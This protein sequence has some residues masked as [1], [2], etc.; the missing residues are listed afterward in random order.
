MDYQASTGGKI[1]Q[2]QEYFLKRLLLASCLL[3]TT[4]LPSFAQVAEN[5]LT[6][7][8][9]ITAEVLINPGTRPNNP[10]VPPSGPINLTNI[11]DVVIFKGSASPLST[12]SVLKNGVVIGTVPVTSNGTFELHIQNLSPGT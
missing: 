2:K 10:P 1:I 12:I 11:T 6:E 4:W 8:V 5:P 9:T 7:T 3:V